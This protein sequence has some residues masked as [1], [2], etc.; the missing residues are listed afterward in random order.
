MRF[1]IVPVI[2]ALVL[3]SSACS[4]DNS[5]GVTDAS[6][7]DSRRRRSTPDT[8]GRDDPGIRDVTADT[9][10]TVEAD[11]PI[12]DTNIPDTNVPDT[13]VTDTSASDLVDAASLV[14]AECLG[15]C[16][17]LCTFLEACDK[18]VPSCVLTCAQSPRYQQ[19]SAAAC[20]EGTAVIG[21]E[22]CRLWRDCNGMSCAID[23]MCLEII[24][25]LSYECA[26]ICDRTQAEPPCPGGV[27]CTAV[28]DAA[29]RV[30]TSLG[31]CWSLL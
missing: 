8:G 17:A 6:E 21:L 18:H 7:E 27:R 22:D 28:T 16:N 15:F 20:N 10:D 1:L 13:V 29:M 30:M 5:S 3:S 9:A 31:M 25:G 11:V 12:V 2:L 26:P 24:P 4:D 14:S 23:E 19:L